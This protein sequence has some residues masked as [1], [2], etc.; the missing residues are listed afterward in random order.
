MEP[1]GAPVRHDHQ[2]VVNCVVTRPNPAAVAQIAETYTAF[3]L[4]RMGKYGACS[5]RIKPLSHGMRMCGPAITQLGA[6]LTVRRMAIDL[7]EEGDVLVVAAGGIDDYACFGDG[8]ALRMA[9]K[10]MAGV[11]IDGSVRDAGFL[12]EM[13]FPT[14]SRGVT[15]RNYHYPVAAEYGGVNVPVNCGGVA[16]HPGDLVLGDDDGIVIVP[17]EMVDRIAEMVSADI[18]EER[19]FRAGMTSFVPFDVEDDLRARGYT[20]NR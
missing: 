11:V 7:A 19:A 12:R 10:G 20:F 9:R 6:D 8:T 15:P 18:A 5:P 2:G 16:I 4:D 14:F 3:V 17:L 13:G 1:K